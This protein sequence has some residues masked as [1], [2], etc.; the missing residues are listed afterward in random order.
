MAADVSVA[1]WSDSELG[2]TANIPRAP[3]PEISPEWLGKPIPKS[4]TQQ[5]CAAR[6]EAVRRR[7][8]VETSHCADIDPAY[9]AEVLE[10]AKE[11]QHRA[12]SLLKLERPPVIQGGEVVQRDAL[13]PKRADIADTL[14]RPNQFAVDASL[15]RTSLLVQPQSDVLALGLDAAQSIKAKNSLEKMLAHQLGMLHSVSMRV[16]D[17]GM[18]AKGSEGVGLLNAATRMMAAYQQGVLTVRQL[19]SKGKQTVVVKHVTVGPGGQAVIGNVAPR[20]R[21][22]K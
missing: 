2:P 17:Q 18:R 19:R 16:M 9:T 6:Q 10:G 13:T 22:K 5:A 1:A 3:V 20:G 12:N 11:F 8:W 4:R 21:R 14:A 7:R 15:E